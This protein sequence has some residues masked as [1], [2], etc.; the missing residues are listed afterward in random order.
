MFGQAASI[1]LGE[2]DAIDVVSNAT[3]PEPVYPS[4]G[5]RGGNISF[6]RGGAGL[7]DGSYQVKLLAAE[8]LSQMMPLTTEDSIP[9]LRVTDYILK[10]DASSHDVVLSEWNTASFDDVAVRTNLRSAQ[11][12]FRCPAFSFLV[13]SA[14][15]VHVLCLELL[16]THGDVV[17]WTEVVGDRVGPRSRHL[18]LPPVEPAK[19]MEKPSLRA[20]GPSVDVEI[21][22]RAASRRS[23]GG[24][25]GSQTSSFASEGVDFSGQ[26]GG[27]QSPEKSM[28][29]QELKDTATPSAAPHPSRRRRSTKAPTEAPQAATIPGEELPTV[30]RYSPA[31][32]L[33]ARQ[34]SKSPGSAGS[35]QSQVSDGALPSIG[36]EASR[37]QLM[38]RPVAIAID[39]IVGMPLC[40]VCTRIRAFVADAVDPTTGQLTGATIGADGLYVCANLGAIQDLRSPCAE[41]RFSES[42]LEVFAGGLTTVVLLIDCALRDGRGWVTVGHAVLPARASQAPGLYESRVRLG[43][44]SPLVAENRDEA[45][46]LRAALAANQPTADDFIPLMH[47]WWR[48]GVSS[49][50]VA[51]RYV[52]DLPAFAPTSFEAHLR[53]MRDHSSLVAAQRTPLSAARVTSEREA[54]ALFDPKELREDPC[55]VLSYLAPHEEPSDVFC[56]VEGLLGAPLVPKAL[57]KVNVE[58]VTTQQSSSLIGAPANRSGFTSLHNFKAPLVAPMFQEDPIVFPSVPHHPQSYLILW[59]YSV[60]TTKQGAE[61][62]QRVGWAVTRLLLDDQFVR[63]GRV[64][65]PLFD[66][67]PPKALLDDLAKP[68]S[69]LEDVVLRHLQDSKIT[70][71]S[72]RILI[73]LSQGYWGRVIE[74]CSKRGPYSSCKTVFIKHISQ[75]KLARFEVPPAGSLSKPLSAMF[76]STGDATRVQNEANLRFSNYLRDCVEPAEQLAQPATSVKSAEPPP[77]TRDHRLQSFNSFQAK[78]AAVAQPTAPPTAPAPASHASRH[79]AEPD[80]GPVLA[81]PLSPAQASKVPFSPTLTSDPHKETNQQKSLAQPA[82]TAEVRTPTKPTGAPPI[83]STA[84]SAAPQKVTSEAPMPLS[85][86]YSP[87]KP[88]VPRLRS[89]G[90]VRSGSF[91]GSSGLAEQAPQEQRTPTSSDAPGL[92]P[93][94]R[95]QSVA[96]PSLA[97]SGIPDGSASA[98]RPL[99]PAVPEDSPPQRARASSVL[100]GGILR[101]FRDQVN[102]DVMQQEANLFGVANPRVLLNVDAVTGC[103]FSFIMI[104]ILVFVSDRA[105][106]SKQLTFS[107]SIRDATCFSRPADFF[108]YQDT[109]SPCGEPTF[110]TNSQFVTYVNDKSLATVIVEGARQDKSWATIGHSVLVLA[111]FLQSGRFRSRVRAGDPRVSFELQ[112]DIPRRVVHLADYVPA[113]FVRWRRNTDVLKGAKD[114]AGWELP[115]TDSEKLLLDDR[116]AFPSRKFPWNYQIVSAKDTPKAFDQ[117]VSMIQAE[118]SSYIAK[119]NKA[120][121]VFVKVEGLSGLVLTAQQMQAMMFAASENSTGTSHVIYKVEV[122]L[123]GQHALTARND[124]TTHGVTFND[125]PFVFKEPFYEP[126]VVALFRVFAVSLGKTPETT[127]VQFVAWTVMKL[128]VDAYYLR[129]GRVALPLFTGQCPPREQLEID[130]HSTEELLRQLATSSNPPCQLYHPGALLR[131]ATGETERSAEILCRRGIHKTSKTVIP[132]GP[133]WTEHFSAAVAEDTFLRVVTGANL[134]KGAGQN[135]PGASSNTAILGLLSAEQDQAIHNKVHS[136]ALAM[137]SH[138]RR[139]SHPPPPAPA[140]PPVAAS[141]PTPHKSDSG[142]AAGGDAAAKQPSFVKPAVRPKKVSVSVDGI[143]GLP[144]QA[145]LTRCLVYFADLESTSSSV[146]LTSEALFDKPPEI[147]TFQS[148]SSLVAEP[149]FTTDNS[150]LASVGPRTRA[151]VVVEIAFGKS[152]SAYGH[153]VLP[154]GW[155]LTPQSG[156][157]FTRLRPGDPRGRKVQGHEKSDTEDLSLLLRERLGLVPQNTDSYLPLALIR[158]RRECADAAIAAVPD[159]MCV[160]LTAA[161]HQLHKERLTVGLKRTPQVCAIQSAS[162]C[163]QAFDE[164]RKA[165]DSGDATSYISPYAQDRPCFVWPE[166]IA[167]L[168][169]EKG[170]PQDVVFKVLVRVGDSLGFS[171]LH[172]LS[173]PLSVPAFEP[174]PITFS[175]VPVDEFCCAWFTVFSVNVKTRAI[176][177]IAWSVAKLFVEQHFLRQARISVPLFDGT[178]PPPS[179]V[180]ELA[181]QP[182]E[183]TV[184]KHLFASN[185]KYHTS[186]A[187]L[188]ISQGDSARFGEVTAR[189]VPIPPATAEGP[190]V[191]QSKWK[192]IRKSQLSEF[193]NSQSRGHGQTLMQMLTGSK[194]PSTKDHEA[195][196]AAVAEINAVVMSF[197]QNNGMENLQ[198]GITEE[199]KAAPQPEMERRPSFFARIFS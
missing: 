196:V 188:Q 80:L 70:F 153:A 74:V 171:Q 116:S 68:G 98:P 63:H 86:G 104:R 194:A 186:R 100:G 36:K 21:A 11:S 129:N 170:A 22:S 53:E 27:M 37:Q 69:S 67:A 191:N 60:D 198:K 156:A 54:L 29:P 139:Q 78:A 149:L 23:G 77:F 87:A 141:D 16:D 5:L 56:N 119:F 33:D 19:A 79:L 110:S 130:G 162:D 96:T 12:T 93:R 105:D 115:L 179:F 108:A 26:Q 189:F 75:D 32:G 166:R 72:P 123:F 160:P 193:D 3:S 28:S 59:L 178:A 101:K 41:P 84:T 103:P 195:A 43:D 128:F 133:A 134:Q 62:I 42:S 14:K 144:L 157:Y 113:M 132:K 44:P 17:A 71:T 94:S 45:A 126:S 158:W 118:D 143:T 120:R 163:R 175:G 150:W 6:S 61:G 9:T 117:P 47:V 109:S 192:L 169:G 159:P 97:S 58:L 107:D 48:K 122:E 102:S 145:T 180:Q 73:R 13:A 199:A 18:R 125:P 4:D 147:M 88:V 197:L 148:L 83:S 55:E 40:V 52:P 127:T 34:S 177:A 137:R 135:L 1:M 112:K 154:V 38:S 187:L 111:D 151:V 35:N 91:S 181:S 82:T 89:A 99:Q 131:V 2:Y 49:P 81:S 64:V 10:S 168:F 57:Y 138:H 85:S 51:S 185:I 121:G 24:G 176:K 15:E 114:D 90:T 20:V 182:I 25:M 95:A 167:G 92:P 65:S 190:F 39:R 142:L 76:G 66:K 140:A 165:A 50:A 184:I 161:E 174:E 7:P 152:W 46:R 31:L 172:D 183:Q 155:T 164:S 124:F 106:P 8:E 136:M 30:G 146:P 173:S